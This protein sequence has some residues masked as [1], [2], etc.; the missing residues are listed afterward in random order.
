MPTIRYTHQFDGCFQVIAIF[1]SLMIASFILGVILMPFALLLDVFQIKQ[2]PQVLSYILSF[3]GFLLFLA[4]W[5]GTI[6]VVFSFLIELPDYLYFRLTLGVPLSYKESQKYSILIQP[7][8]NTWRHLKE[9]REIPAKERKQH[10]EYLYNL[11][12]LDLD[13]GVYLNRNVPSSI[14]DYYCDNCNGPMLLSDPVCLIC[15]LGADEEA[16]KLRRKPRT[17]RQ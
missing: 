6:Y 4:I 10:L 2:L 15:G 7:Q 17:N 12:Y 8:G 11:R 13:G 9:L 5:G 3:F 1:G 14:D 16:P